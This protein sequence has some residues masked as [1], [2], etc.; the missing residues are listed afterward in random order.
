MTQEKQP[1]GKSMPGGQPSAGAE[2]TNAEAPA[3]E[4]TKSLDEAKKKAAEYLEGWQRE[5]A[6]TLNYKRRVEQDFTQM[7]TLANA[8]LIVSILPVIDDLERAFIAMP[9]KLQSLSWV[10]GIKLIYRKLKAIM[11][12]QGVTEIPAKGKPFDPKFHE[13]V[14]YQ[15]G[16]DGIVVEELQ[17]GYMLNGTVLRSSLVAVGKSNKAKAPGTE[18]RTTTEAA[19]EDKEV[20]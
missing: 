5:R 13:A 18:D 12:A 6:D 20:E 3:E 8:S 1:D 4:L 9:A 2:E 14:T 19:I 7:K 16:E 15:E 10:D 11:E 17:K